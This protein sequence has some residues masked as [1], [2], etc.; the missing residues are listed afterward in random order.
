MQASK[1][2]SIVLLILVS[3]FHLQSQ[4]KIE[5]L[6]QATATAI[7]KNKYL[8]SEYL[9]YESLKTYQSSYLDFGKTSLYYSYDD[10]NITPANR[11]LDVFGISQT[12]SFPTFYSRQK[13]LFQNQ[14]EL[15]L[16]TYNVYLNR[17]KREVELNYNEIQYL[18]NR[19]RMVIELDS[20]GNLFIN[21]SNRRYELGEIDL[22]EN[23][24]LKTTLNRLTVQKIE[25]EQDFKSSYERLKVLLN[26]SDTIIL[27]VEEMTL[28]SIDTLLLENNPTFKYYEAL[29]YTSDSYVKVLRNDL[30]PEISLQY[31]MGF[32]RTENSDKTNYPGYS[33]GL[34]FPL[35]FNAQSSRIKAAKI[36]NEKTTQL[37]SAYRDT[38]QS[39]VESYL[40]ELEK[41]DRV[42]TFYE[43]EGVPN[44][45]QLGLAARRS[46]ESGNYD[47]SQLIIAIQNAIE[48]ELEYLKAIS[49]YNS[50]V[51]KINY[52]GSEIP[53][54]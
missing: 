17:L 11:N 33:I 5:S 35:V 39:R 16:S 10:N 25:A 26:E 31:F 14:T 45:S 48:I 43:T 40:Q 24:T 6:D 2:G 36:Q 30:W 13:Q 22:L 53:N 50:I 46:F 52:L 47:I 8:Q 1:I 42:I 23:A 49:D 38:W 37:I 34:T 9:N 21:T 4:V 15:G 3:S 54:Q 18:L 29:N 41:H 44:A 32:E 51:I 7:Q 12:F 28:R 27:R 20:L 19:L